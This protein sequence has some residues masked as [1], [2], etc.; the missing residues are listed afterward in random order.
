[1]PHRPVGF[2]EACDAEHEFGHGRSICSSN[3]CGQ[4]QKRDVLLDEEVDEDRDSQSELTPHLVTFEDEEN[5]KT[6]STQSELSK[7]VFKE[8]TDNDLIHITE[9]ADGRQMIPLIPDS[10]TSS[11]VFRNLR[12]TPVNIGTDGLCGCTCLFLVSD[13]AIYAA[14]YYEN[15]AFDPKDEDFNFNREVVRFLENTGDWQAGEDNRHYPGLAK[16]KDNFNPANTKAYIM[17][18]A[19][20]TAG[21]KK[22][23]TFNMDIGEY[24]QQHTNEKSYIQQMKDVVN[25]IIP[26]LENEVHRYKPVD[27]KNEKTLNTKIN[28]RVL[29]Q[30]DPSDPKKM[31][32]FF[33]NKQVK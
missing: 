10:S 3:S 19:K 15:L 29:F 30:F 21:R 7:R 27:C 25:E 14:H 23:A 31:R 6:L 26:G 4:N 11:S 28:G 33:E 32:L 8:Y 22:A 13:T 18:P 20:E 12:R 1:M 9:N 2:L 24:E 16:V 5:N 17:T